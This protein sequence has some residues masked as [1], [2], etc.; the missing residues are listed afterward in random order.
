VKPGVN[1]LIGLPCY[2]GRL[3]AETAMSLVGTAQLLHRR[4]PHDLL[5]VPNLA[6]VAWARNVLAHA[7]LAGGFSHLLQ[8]DDDVSW[9]PEDVPWLLSHGVDLVVGAC[10]M[11]GA[12]Q[13]FNVHGPRRVADSPLLRCDYAGAAFMLLSRGCLVKMASNSPL[14]VEPTFTRMIFD[15][16]L[17]DGRYLGEDVDFCLRWRDLG[18]TVYV[19]PAVALVHFAGEVAL[20]KPYHQALADGTAGPVLPA[21]EAQ[22]R[23]PEPAA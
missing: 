8:I 4:V 6:P 10:P 2:S 20:S 15:T 13:T 21:E 1:I 11:R 22:Q 5:I 9:N 16:R 14:T 19:D 3:H 18:G 7:A 23:Q 12:E 17:V